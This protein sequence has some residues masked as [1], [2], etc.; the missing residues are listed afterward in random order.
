MR[1]LLNILAAAT[2][3][4][5]PALTA[6]CK[7]KAKS[8]EDKYKDSSVENLPNGPL[9][10]KIL[11]T[12]LFTKATIAN[13]HENLN[14]YTPSMLQM[15]MRLPDSYKDK[16]GNIVDIDYYRGKYLNKNN[17]MPLTTLSSNYDY[18]NLLDN[19]L[20]NT[21][22][23]TK[24]KISDYSDKDPLPSIPNLTK[25]SNMLNYWYDGGPLS[26]YSIVKEI[27]P[28]KCDDKRI[29]Q[30]IVDACNKAI[31]EMPRTTYFY[32]FNMDYSPMAT[33]DIKFDTD[34][35][36]NFIIN[37]QK[38]AAGGPFKTAQKSEEQDK[39]SI[40]LQ[41][42]SMADMFTD[43]SQSKTYINQLNKFL[44]LSGDSDGTFMGSILGAIYY[45]IFASPKLPNDP[46]KENANYTFAKFGVTKALQLLRKDSTERQAIKQKIDVFFDAQ[47]QVFSDLLAVRPMQPGLDLNKPEGQ[48][49]N[50]DAMWNGKT[51]N[52]RLVDLLFKK[53]ASTK[54]LAELFTDFGEYLDDLYTKADV[55]CQEEAN[56]SIS[57]FLKLAA[58]VVTPGFKVVLQS[59][60]KMMLSKSEGG[61]GTLS[62]NDINRFAVALS[63]G[64]LQSA[65]ALTEVSKLPW[66]EATDQEQNQ[67]KITQ[68]LTGSDDPSTPTK[69]SFMDLAFTWFND[70]TQPVRALLNKLYFD[71]DSETRKDLLAINNALYEYSNNLLLGA[72]WNISNGQLEENKLSYDI[73]YKGTGDADVVANLDLHQN[74]YIPKSEIKTYQDLNAAYLNA[75][76]NRDLD[77]FMKYDGLGNNYQKVHYKY[78]VTWMNINPGDDS[79]QYWVISNIQW[80]AKDISGQWKRYYDAIE[81]D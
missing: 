72:N 70:S 12:T 32:N 51:P 33:K 18:M 24:K 77:W 27:L 66:S 4:A 43:R 29:N 17:G 68:L 69:D 5:T 9:K 3:A 21:E 10:S 38:F 64:I 6:S 41:L 42:I 47:S 22:K 39:L 65:N 19:E 11:Q 7:T 54:S 74:W 57:S 79:H 52:L 67:T 63:K 40:I 81:N 48:Y 61:L 44:A 28:T 26:N 13:R 71:P 15:L 1:K 80:F 35:N 75:L 58:N 53:D 46:T 8:A 30:N 34:T 16:D 36:Q 31:F 59:M 56:N 49:K 50:R 2:L 76:G 78:K 73:E 45:Q 20:Y 14:T 23:Q 25:N 55:E 60:S 37:N 62:V